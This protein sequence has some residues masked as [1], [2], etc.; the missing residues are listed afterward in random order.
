[1]LKKWVFFSMLLV[2]SSCGGNDVFYQYETVPANGWHQ[3]TAIH[4]NVNIADTVSRYNVYVN[5][6][7][8]GEYPHQNLWLFIEQQSPDSTLFVDS[9][10]FY[11]ADQRGKWLGSGVGSVYEMP[12][13][14]RQNIQFPDSGNYSFSFRQGMR[15]S[16]LTG[17]NDLGLRIEKVSQK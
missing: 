16:V 6:R 9:I 4:F 11:L 3:D 17:L 5:V 13:L 1:M 2:L 14:Y 7:N 15:D 12:V 10:N 8:R